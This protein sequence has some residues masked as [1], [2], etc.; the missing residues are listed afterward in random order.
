LGYVFDPHTL[1]QIA[2]AAV[3]QSP[4]EMVHTVGEGLRRSY[5]EQ[6]DVGQPWILSL[7]GGTTGMIKVFHASITEYVAIYGAALGTSGFSGRFQLEIHDIVLTGQ[8]TT[9]LES[10]PL[11]RDVF[12]PGDHAVLPRG[13]TKGWGNGDDTWMLEYARGFVPSALPFGLGDALFSAMDPQTLLR[14]LA[15][16]GTLTLRNLLRGK[17]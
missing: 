6:V 8:M 9:F 13:D 14:T 7:F 10:R 15:I 2:R 12:A 4:Q 16:Y 3:G 1:E 17:I 5:A 11:Q